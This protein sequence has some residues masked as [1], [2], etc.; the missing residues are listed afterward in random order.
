MRLFQ[1]FLYFIKRGCDIELVLTMKGLMRNKKMH[2]G[3]D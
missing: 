3:I 2:L 1:G